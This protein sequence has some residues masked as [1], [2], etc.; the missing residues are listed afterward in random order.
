MTL[1]VGG[2][3]LPIAVQVVP[4]QATALILLTP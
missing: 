4:R 2:H 1:V 3:R